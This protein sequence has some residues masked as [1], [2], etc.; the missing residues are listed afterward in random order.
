MKRI[1]IIAILAVLGV[2]CSKDYLETAP[3]DKIASTDVFN[4]VEGAQ[5]VVNGI[6][7]SMRVSIDNTHDSF[8]VKAV[9]LATD[10]MQGDVLMYAPH[11][12][13][14]D[15]QL[16]NNAPS[17]RRPKFIWTM[18]YQVI[19]NS[20]Y[21][22]TNIDKI[23]SENNDFRNFVKAEA[24]TLRAYSYF[25]LIQLYQNTYKGHEQD[26]GIPVYTE[27]TKEGK[28]RGTVKEVYAQIT[29]DLD[30]AI[31]LF[32]GSAYGDAD[33]STPNGNLAKAVRANVALVMNDWAKASVLAKEARKGY[34]LNTAS[35]YTSG[36]GD[37]SKMVWMW[38]LPVNDEQSGIYASFFSHIDP[39]IDGYAGLGYSPKGMTYQGSQA[40]Y[41]KIQD[42]DVRKSLVRNGKYGVPESFKFSSSKGF[43]ADYVMMR[44]EEMLLVEAEALANQGDLDGAKGLIQ[45]LWNNRFEK[46]IPTV[47]FNSK[48]DALSKIYLERRIELWGEGKALLDVKRL[49]KGVLRSDAGHNYVGGANVDYPA[50][51]PRFT[52]VIPQDEIDNNPKISEEDNNPTP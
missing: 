12:F 13:M 25:K 52:Y 5:S 32:D 39:T 17:Y 24:L 50:E 44:P 35:Q 34:A 16:S 4:S 6:L 3:S 29:K 38:G 1:I 21:V 22:I 23:Q 31:Q 28:A 10:L 11:W 19:N 46:N 43:S 40:L 42:G 37:L 26:A 33:V 36:F 41:P 27:P 9:D 14:Y 15:Y 20:N 7:R 48:E 2:S 8:G 18:F 51:S 47:V 49:K 30:L 45:K